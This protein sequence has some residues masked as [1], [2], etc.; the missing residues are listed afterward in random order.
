MKAPLSSVAERIRYA[1]HALTL[2]AAAARSDG[3]DIDDVDG[4]LEAIHV[5][6]DDAL[7]ELEPLRNA[8]GEVLNWRTGGDSGG[9]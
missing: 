6:A 9:R 4:L 1:R 2:I 5:A 7:R 8:P 3:D